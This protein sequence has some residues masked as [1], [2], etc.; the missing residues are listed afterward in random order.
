MILRDK[1]IIYVYG[2]KDEFITADRLNEMQN[3]SN[4]LDVSP[5]ILTFN[6]GHTVDEQLLKQL[7]VYNSG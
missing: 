3:I 2:K 4:Q 6:G 7:F 5:T 1:K